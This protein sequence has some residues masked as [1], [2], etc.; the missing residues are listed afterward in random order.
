MRVPVLAAGGVVDSRTIRAAFQ[1]GAS[2]VQVGTLFIPSLES[3]AS[4]PYKDAVIAAKDTDTA[5]TRAFSGRWARGIRNEFMRTMEASGIAIPDYTIQNSL[6]AGLRAYGQKNNHPE[7]VSLWA[8]QS[9]GKARRGGT[10]DILQG[11]VKGIDY[12]WA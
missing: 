12:L 9:A 7:V 1:L 8:G 11:L 4:E 2:G 3:A 6:T 5:L 10:A